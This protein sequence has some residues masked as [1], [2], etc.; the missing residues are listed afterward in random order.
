MTKKNAVIILIICLCIVFSI[1]IYEKKQKNSI[2]EGIYIDKVYVGNLNKYE[3]IKRLQNHI[4]E[5][6][7][8]Y[9]V[10]YYNDYKWYLEKSEI[11]ELDLNKTVNDALRYGRNTFF[12]NTFLTRI[13][14]KNSPVIMPFSY[15]INEKIFKE[16]LKDIKSKI[17][18]EPR[19]AYFYIDKN[20]VQI[21]EEVVGITVDENRLRKYIKK[22]KASTKINIPTRELMA[23]RTANLLR[24]MDIKY[25]TMEF[26]TKFNKLN[27]NRTKNIRLA[28]NKL[29]GYILRPKEIFSFNKVVGERSIENG[30]KKA[31]IFVE[32]EIVSGIGGGVCQVS[33]T[34]YNLAL[35]LDLEIIERKNHSKP[36]DYVPLGQD[37]TVEYDLIDL[38]FC[39]NTDGYLVLFTIVEDNVLKIM[40]Y[41]DSKRNEKISLCSKIIKKIPPPISIKND[42]D[43]KK[44]N[45][46]I[47]KGKDGYQ[48]ET[49]KQYVG[50]KEKKLVSIDIYNPTETIIFVGKKTC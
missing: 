38:K 29:N 6:E 42:Y 32:N 18:K 17:Y 31:P 4:K 16:L 24:K 2:L 45:I 47:R 26:S 21:A 33:S 41:S 1:Y 49:W 10:L 25:K 44:G 12:I 23:T 5:Y 30:Y 50:K 28:A 14:L 40:A 3:A 11:L 15:S 8:K 34:I 20:K 46:E 35:L 36:V 7:N 37:A 9:F 27:K 22:S 39:N 48:V 19:D 43:L 13:K